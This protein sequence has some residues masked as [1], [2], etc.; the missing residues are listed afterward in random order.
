MGSLSTLEARATIEVRLGTPNAVEEN[1][2]G[3]VP[4]RLNGPVSKTGM[5]LRSIEGSNPSLSASLRSERSGERRLSRRSV[6]EGGQVPSAPPLRNAFQHA[7]ANLF[8]PQ[9]VCDLPAFGVREKEDIADAARFGCDD[10]V[11]AIHIRRRQG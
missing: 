7:V 6:S 2:H 10:G 4:E 5:G 3:E 11:S 9:R 8:Q 1:W